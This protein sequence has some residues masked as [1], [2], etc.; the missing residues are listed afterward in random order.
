MSAA[1]EGTQ[2]TVALADQA[3]TVSAEENAAT[4]NAADGTQLT[5][6]REAQAATVSADKKA[7]VVSAGCSR[8]EGSGSEWRSK[9]EGS[10]TDWGSR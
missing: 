4:V 9:K 1:T 8:W 7:T 2:V 3:A 6:A 10:N 5:I